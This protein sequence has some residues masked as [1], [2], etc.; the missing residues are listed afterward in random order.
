MFLQVSRLC[1][2]GLVSNA[3]ISPTCA[4][5]VSNHNNHKLQENGLLVHAK[6]SVKTHQT[7]LWYNLFV[8]EDKLDSLLN[9][10]EKST[11]LLMEY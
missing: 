6:A 7:N 5:N 2:Q 3:H 4:A 11:D 8:A 1:I 9:F 10:V